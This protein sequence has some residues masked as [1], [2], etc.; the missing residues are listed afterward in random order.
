MIWRNDV[1]KWIWIMSLSDGFERWIW[2]KINLRK[3][4]EN[5]NWFWEFDLKIELKW[6][7]D[8]NVKSESLN[9]LEFWL[10]GWWRW[11]RWWRWRWWIVIPKTA[12]HGRGQ[13]GKKGKIELLQNMKNG[14]GD[15]YICFKVPIGPTDHAKKVWKKWGAH[16]FFCPAIRSSKIYGRAIL[17]L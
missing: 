7:R 1:E 3:Q 5:W 8:M 17:G 16:G 9:F 11:W 2:L 4:F 12:T 15:F 6:I 13:K 10:V 14:K